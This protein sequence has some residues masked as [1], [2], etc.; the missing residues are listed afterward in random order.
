MINY[1]LNCFWHEDDSVT[2]T[3]KSLI[4]TFPGKPLT[5]TS[6]CVM[7]EVVGN[8]YFNSKPWIN[9]YGVCSDFVKEI[10]NGR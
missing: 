5:K 8:E 4:W 10:K 7:P 1:N 6:I 2:L 3:S 9:C